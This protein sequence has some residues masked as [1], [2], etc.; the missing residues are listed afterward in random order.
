MVLPVKV[1]EV[2]GLE[3]NPLD[4]LTGWKEVEKVEGE[5]DLQLVTEIIETKDKEGVGLRG[6]HQGLLP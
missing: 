5:E 6:L 1:F 3:G 2:R 4:K